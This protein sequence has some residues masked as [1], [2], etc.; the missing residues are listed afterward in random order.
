MAGPED[1]GLRRLLYAFLRIN[2][3]F[4]QDLPRFDTAE[5]QILPK[6]R[7][8]RQSS[9]QK[10]IFRLCYNITVRTILTQQKGATDGA[11]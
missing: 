4:L 2:I 1:N 7:V 6:K 11:I 5:A 9:A 8:L 3:R 10:G